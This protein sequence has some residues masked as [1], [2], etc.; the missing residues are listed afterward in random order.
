[1]GHTISQNNQQEMAMPESKQHLKEQIIKE[2]K[3]HGNLSRAA[4]RLDVNRRTIFRWR[5]NDTVFGNR[6]ESAIK[7]AT[8]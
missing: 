1:M 5:E 6:I 2:V 4:R 3:Q 7:E 8:Q